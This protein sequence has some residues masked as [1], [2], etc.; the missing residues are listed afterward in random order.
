MLKTLGL[1]FSFVK[2]WF[3]NQNN[4]LEIEGKFNMTLFIG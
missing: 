2:I 3:P 4:N 1:E